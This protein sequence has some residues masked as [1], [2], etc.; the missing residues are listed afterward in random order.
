MREALEIT[1]ATNIP[2]PCT[3]NQP[4]QTN[5]TASGDQLQSLLE[6]IES[7]LEQDPF[8][9]R[10]MLLALSTGIRRVNITIPE[11][12]LTRVDRYV[13]EHRFDS[14]SGFLVQAAESFI[15]QHQ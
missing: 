1:P 13:K 11:R 12:L 4:T 9:G 10:A 8:T 14:R 15:S 3:K 2:T 6:A 5:F 7:D